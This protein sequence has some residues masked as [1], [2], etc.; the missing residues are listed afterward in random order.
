MMPILVAG[1]GSEVTVT[2]VKGDDK[3]KIFIQNLGLHVGTKVK[4]ISAHDGD[5]IVLVKDARIALTRSFASRVM[6]QPA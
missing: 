4:V 2:Q 5:L 6:V 1:E 3:T